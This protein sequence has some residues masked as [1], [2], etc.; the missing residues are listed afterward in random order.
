FVAKAFTLGL[1][2]D[3]GTG[4]ISASLAP[5]IVVDAKF[6]AK[7]LDFDKWLASLK[8]P[9]E[10]AAPEP[11]TPLHLAPQPA[12]PAPR[13]P[14]LS[15]DA[16]VALE[17]GE[18]IYNKQPVRDLVLELETRGGAVAVPRFNVVLPGDLRMEARS[19]MSGDA[20]R[21]IVA[22]EFSLQGSKLRDTLT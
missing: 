15:I 22:G 3:S 8:L 6:A 10:V 11:T 12:A 9:A 13:R 7:R 18:V 1:G 16:K 17:A 20:A 4:S 19:T 21:P 2:D 5:A 14:L